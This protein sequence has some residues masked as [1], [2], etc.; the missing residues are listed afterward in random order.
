[1]IKKFLDVLFLLSFIAIYFIAGSMEQEYIS[2][3]QAVIAFLVDF[4]VMG[5]SGYASEEK[6]KSLHRGHGTDS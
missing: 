1:M 5:I 2:F 3:G 6:E 4:A